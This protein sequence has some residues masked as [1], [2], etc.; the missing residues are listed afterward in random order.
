MT[1]HGPHNPI[2]RIPGDAIDRQIEGS[3]RR[4]FT[5]PS[6]I[7][8]SAMLAGGLAAHT[9][10]AGSAGFWRLEMPT[11]SLRNAA[12]LLLAASIWL[13]SGYLILD[14]VGSSS[15]SASRVRGPG[16]VVSDGDLFTSPPLQDL[17]RAFEVHANLGADQGSDLLDEGHGGAMAIQANRVGDPVQNVTAP[18]TQEQLWGELRQQAILAAGGSA[19]AQ[20]D[21]VR[22]SN[23]VELLDVAPRRNKHGGV[24]IAARVDGVLSV[25]VM[26]EGERGRWMAGASL[27]PP[28]RKP[29]LPWGLRLHSAK[30]ENGL[31]YEITQTDVPALLPLLVPE[32]KITAKLNVSRG[33]TPGGRSA[34]MP[35]PLE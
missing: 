33:M 16:T 18:R 7:A 32:A 24:M 14:E 10:S 4:Q 26:Q 25:A 29:A 28:Q 3:L 12:G 6:A 8:P 13:V 23:R 15:R 31:G 30:F 11:L 17:V 27:T 1:P 2:Q 21:Q 5:V 22:A 19:G 20:V 35:A 34:V 9:S